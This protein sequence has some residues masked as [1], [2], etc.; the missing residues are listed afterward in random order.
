[1]NQTNLI[2]NMQ[3]I[4]G[5]LDILIKYIEKSPV[6]EVQG[7]LVCCSIGKTTRL[8]KYSDDGKKEYLGEDKKDL[9]K[10]L[11]RKKHY[12]KM[13]ETAK[14]ER[15]KLLRCIKI[16][17]TGRQLA[18][19]DKVYSSLHKAVQGLI[20]PFKMTDD[21]FALNWLKSNKILRNRKLLNGQ[22]RTLKGEYVKSKS[23]VIIADRLTFNN[24]PYIYEASAVLDDWTSIRYP[25]F[26]ILNKRTRKEYYWEHLGKM[27][28]E[29]YAVGN[30]IKI[31][32]FAKNG[33][34]LGKN[35]ILSVECKDRPLSTEYVDT[36]IKEILI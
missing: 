18:D 8:Y 33:I 13:L 14:R 36:I 34:I 17:T 11:A 9:I 32:Q 26:M 22:Y 28:D 25:D 30:Q 35:L 24:V 6:M 27:G 10:E 3:E 23:E 5:E 12:E 15:E 7:R 1:M 19:I 16:L 20:G 31:E 4:L 29:E 21:G 2:E